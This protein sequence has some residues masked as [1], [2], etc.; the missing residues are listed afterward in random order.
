MSVLIAA[1]AWWIFATFLEVK[2][3]PVD[4]QYPAQFALLTAAGIGGV[5]A[6]VVAYRRQ[7]VHEGGLFVERFGAAA[8]QLGDPDPAVRIAGAYAMAGVA[9]EGTPAQLQ[10]CVDVLCGYLRL[11][12][13]SE[14]GSSGLFER[15][16]RSEKTGWEHTHVLRTNDRQVRQT[17]QSI[18]AGHL[19][20]GA[21]VG[22][23]NSNVDFHGVHFEDADFGGAHFY[24]DT[25]F[26]GALFSG[27]TWF[28]D[29]HFA[30]TTSFTRAHFIGTTWFQ[31]THFI[32]AAPLN[33]GTRF[34]RISWFGGDP[35]AGGTS[36]T[37]AEFVG[38]THFTGAHFIGDTHFDG[39]H[40]AAE[41]TFLSARFPRSGRTSF[42]FPGKWDP[43]PYFDWSRDATLKPPNVQPDRWP[44]R[45]LRRSA[46]G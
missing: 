25:R 38:D 30:G 32:G 9:D 12:Y 11:P 23:N 19:R 22:W 33:E 10:Q 15:K 42:A 39:A 18:I 28:T 2:A 40:F 6:L 13:S 1:A 7:R 5:V 35:F 4:R 16:S 8:K 31:G 45:T 37:N 26:D 43:A 21:T 17:I 24:G 14:H 29:V 34:T 27:K 20:P 3:D 44:P 36:F 41:V 46:S